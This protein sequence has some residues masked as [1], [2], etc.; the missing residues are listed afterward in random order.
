METSNMFVNNVRGAILARFPSEAAFASKLGWTRQR[1][2]GFT[3]GIREPKL[4]DVQAMA[5]GLNMETSVL[6]EFFLQLRSQKC[7]SQ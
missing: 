6:A 7:D 4:S 3:S 2:N 5:S 1:L